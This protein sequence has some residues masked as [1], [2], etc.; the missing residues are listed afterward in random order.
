MTAKLISMSPTANS[1]LPA[2]TSQPPGVDYLVLELTDPKSVWYDIRLAEMSG[3]DYIFVPQYL[4]SAFDEIYPLQEFLINLESISNTRATR[5]KLIGYKQD[6]D[7][8]LHFERIVIDWAGDIA[9]CWRKE[10]LEF[11]P[12]LEFIEML[13]E[14]SE[15]FVL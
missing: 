11:S 9:L 3:C 6:S 13:F 15:A 1:T 4:F 10:S 12:Q 7:N 5:A 14:H 2:P 8:L